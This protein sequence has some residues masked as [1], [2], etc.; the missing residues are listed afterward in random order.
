MMMQLKEIYKGRTLLQSLKEVKTV[1]A[2]LQA[3]EHIEGSNFWY[4]TPSLFRLLP[5]WSL[6]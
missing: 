2:K 5:V 4:K 6:T 3:P 1:T